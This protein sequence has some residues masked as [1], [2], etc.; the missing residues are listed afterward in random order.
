M[1]ILWRG[2]LIVS[3]V[4]F[5]NSVVLANQESNPFL[6]DSFQELVGEGL[7]QDVDVFTLPSEQ[8]FLSA[9]VT[10]F[11]GLNAKLRLG[12]YVQPAVVQPGATA[13]L[14]LIAVPDSGYHVYPYADTDELGVSKPT[15]IV[16]TEG[17]M[18]GRAK[19]DAV[20]KYQPPIQEGE[21]EIPYHPGNVTWMIDIFVPSETAAGSYRTVGVMGYQTCTDT[22][23]DLPRGVMFEVAFVVGPDEQ[24]GKVPV[25]FG[26]A[27]YA[28]ASESAVRRQASG[29]WPA[30]ESGADPQAMSSSRGQAMSSSR[31]ETVAA[32]EIVGK[33]ERHRAQGEHST[34]YLLATAFL[35]GLI[36]NVMPCVLPVIGLKL[37]A[38]VEQAGE[39]RWR[40]FELNLWYSLGLM[41]VFMVL[42]LLAVSMGLG[43]GEQFSS[44]TFNLVLLFVVFVFGLAMLGVWEIPIPGF[45]G[46]GAAVDA[47]ER[48]GRLG[49][50][51]KGALTTVLATPCTGPML[52]P[53]LAWATK[54]P[55][56]LTYAT[57]MTVGLGMASPYL[58]IGAVPK[59]IAFLPKPGNWMNL[60]KQLMGFV[61]MGTVV[62]IFSFLD[63]DYI[64]QALSVLVSLG[65]ACW[66]V[67][68]TPFSATLRM[69]VKAWIVGTVVVGTTMASM[70]Y[71]LPA[72]SVNRLMWEPYTR[73]S[74][75]EHLEQGK[76]VFIDFTADW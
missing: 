58:L 24:A 4:F 34:I 36:L 13:T 42:A 20:V 29:T 56:W 52:G 12:G 16:T 44:T 72:L 46:A 25:E 61:L 6:S 53:A 57:F 60:F 35:A 70:F 71:V 39:N 15:L 48:E 55:A 23:C 27:S 51:C 11:R 2:P 1:N 47:T 31:A 10:A 62:F 75:D 63:D 21:P 64:V 14:V 40:I 66:W 59:L 18:A 22:S 38:F 65:F 8:P 7:S 69:K 67:G 28:D 43:W 54:Q 3:C 76:T 26:E 9:G 68:Q 33:T 73:A 74:L 17:F 19:T 30:V 41:A 50:F 45:I 32:S 49:A 5:V 37:M